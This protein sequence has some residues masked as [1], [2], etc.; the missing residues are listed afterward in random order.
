MFQK[1][2]TLVSMPGTK[3]ISLSELKAQA[4]QKGLDTFD[5]VI[6]LGDKNYI[7]I[8]KEA[9]M[10][11]AKVITPVEGLPIGKAMKLIK[12]LSARDQN[13]FRSSQNKPF[14]RSL[15]SPQEALPDALSNLIDIAFIFFKECF[16]TFQQKVRIS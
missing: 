13:D 7:E 6:A 9:F 10:S 1:I 14:R 2:M 3:P 5:V 4:K 11:S 8:V 15:S 12:S 16:T